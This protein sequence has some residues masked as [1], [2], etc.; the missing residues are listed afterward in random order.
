MSL[1]HFWHILGRTFC[2]LLVVRY[3]LL[4]ARYFL[5]VARYFLLFAR[6]CLLVTRY[7]LASF[8]RQ[9]LDYKSHVLPLST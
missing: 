7:F 4:F 1:Q 3:S 6:Y 2:L 8:Y 9:L 5:L